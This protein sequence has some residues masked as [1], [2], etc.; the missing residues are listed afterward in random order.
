[1]PRRTWLLIIVSISALAA[2][3]AQSRPQVEWL[4]YASDPGGTRASPLADVH[5]GN[6]SGLRVA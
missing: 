5:P 4:H 2:A 6:V 1:M 3:Q